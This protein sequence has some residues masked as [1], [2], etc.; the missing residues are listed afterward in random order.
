MSSVPLFEAS[1]IIPVYNQWHF[2]K[3]CLETLADT[4]QGK[5]VEIIVI[6]NASSDDT[7]QEC[8]RLGSKL[9]GEA[10]KYK[11]CPQNINFGPASN[12]GARLACGEYLLFL[13][14]DIELLPG[15]YEPL[16]ADFSHY[17]DIA[18]TGPVLLYPAQEPF[19]HTVQHLGIFVDPTRRLGHLYEGIPAASALASKRRFFQCITAAFLLM[20]RT[21]FLEIGMFDEHYVNGFEDVDLCARLFNK[22]FRMTVNPHCRAIHYTSQT[23]G[24][25]AHDLENSNYYRA[26]TQHLLSPD[27]NIHCK[28]DDLTL[29]V[30]PLLSPWKCEFPHE[31]LLSLEK[32][33]EQAS[34]EELRDLLVSNPF[35]EKGWQRLIALSQSQE[36]QARLRALLAKISYTPDLA[37]SLYQ[38]ACAQHDKDSAANALSDL[39]AFCKPWEEYLASARERLSQWKQILGMED[40]VS[41]YARWLTQEKTF[42]KTCYEPF[43][44]KFWQLA[45]NWRPL[46]PESEWVYTLWRHNV[47]QPRRKGL[48]RSDSFEGPT[49]S[50]LMPLVNPDPEQLKE[51]LASLLAQDCPRWELCVVGDNSVS[52][53]IR[54]LVEKYKTRDARIH[55]FWLNQDKGLSACANKAL[56]MAEQAWVGLYDHRDRLDQ[57][58]LSRFSDVLMNQPDAL[59]LYADNDTIDNHGALRNPRFFKS[60]WD[61]EALLAGSLAVPFCFFASNRL[62]A[63]GGFRKDEDAVLAYDLLLRFTQ[64]QPPSRFLHLPY[65]LYHKHSTEYSGQALKR[66]TESACQ[67]LQAYLDRTEK[68]AKASIL[69]Q[70]S[71]LRAHF[72]LPKSLPRVSLL[73]DTLSDVRQLALLEAYVH[74]LTTKTAYQ[75]CE[76]LILY[77]ASAPYALRAQTKRAAHQEKRLRLLPLAANTTSAE[78][79]TLGATE[80]TGQIFGFLNASLIPLSEGWLEEL[81]SALC[82]EEVGAVAGKLIT[83]KQSTL[84]AGYYIDAE[85]LLRPLFH[86]LPHNAAGYLGNNRLAHSVDALDALCLFTRRETWN[87]AKG[88][89]TSLNEGA[90]EDFCLRLHAMGL[91]AVWWPYAEFYV[92][93]QA[94]LPHFSEKDA[95]LARHTHRKPTLPNLTIE[96]YDISLACQNAQ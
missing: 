92:Q 13:N 87:K 47:G 50:L 60:Q 51:A 23:R 5:A 54:A 90:A 55:V 84:H 69:P 89:D 53:P 79:L 93:K 56:Q 29:H 43:L 57:D 48:P 65:P 96:G 30:S 71:S 25:H 20:P 28:N 15:W 76:L 49:F 4:T 19:G 78:R 82:R 68:G 36:E 75:N 72:A 58:A 34:F 86:G 8:Q 21:L 88:F 74:A 27:W 42:Q 85:G 95:A 33:A 44:E 11:R 18:A 9:F 91:R 66:H 17:T 62:R 37:L 81:V 2:T 39:V 41:E 22:G 32:K 10:F 12:L 63:I 6:D 26:H 14:N 35:W 77:D 3:K 73:I 46:P 52:T 83:P 67:V 61:Q 1:V 7:E 16:L 24:R 64:G 31:K 40:F 38:D 94:L 70:T 45:K 59:L 80:A